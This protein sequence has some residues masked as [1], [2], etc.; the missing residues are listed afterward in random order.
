[1]KRLRLPDWS[2][3]RITIQVVLFVVAI[4]AL[5]LALLYHTN[6]LDIGAVAASIAV[7]IAI[8]AFA[9]KI[10][11]KIQVLFIAASEEGSTAT[12]SIAST[13][14]LPQWIVIVIM[15]VLG[16]MIAGLGVSAVVL[17]ASDTERMKPLAFPD[18]P[19]PNTP[20]TPLPP[21]F[22][23]KCIYDADGPSK[24]AHDIKPDGGVEQQFIATE[25]YIASLNVNIG[26]NSARLSKGR[27][28]PGNDSVR[29]DLLG[30]NKSVVV[31]NNDITIINNGATTFQFRP[32]KVQ[33]G[34]LYWLRLVNKAG[35][36]ISPY[37]LPTPGPH[38]KPPGAK[39]TRVYREV[40]RD[41]VE[42]HD[43][44]LVG[45]VGGAR[46]G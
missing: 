4:A 29:M 19:G 35:I 31:H 32:V 43:A 8:A 39:R 27:V 20:N 13:V 18:A 5:G 41:D 30:S 10:I 25:P 26:I 24:Q 40:N 36:I 46:R 15:A 6:S 23:T 21:G 22:R 1:M 7:F 38:D 16:L 17:F 12:S 42:R 37:M 34:K 11:E 44:V 45:C 9:R 3:R 2:R 28:P 14:V 33:P